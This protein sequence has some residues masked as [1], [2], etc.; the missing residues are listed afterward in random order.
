MRVGEAALPAGE[1]RRPV[2]AVG[3]VGV[4]EP[5]RRP[6]KASTGPTL[7]GGGSNDAA[8]VLLGPGFR[9]PPMGLD[10]SLAGAAAGR[11]AG[12][13]AGALGV[14]PR[15]AGRRRTA[16]WAARLLGDPRRPPAHAG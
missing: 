11:D 16:S 7:P 5:H 10:R 6:R 3:H 4:L 12:H 14:L 15:P 8:A 2:T 1:R 9:D 13:A